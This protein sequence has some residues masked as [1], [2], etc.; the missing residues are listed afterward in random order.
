MKMCDEKNIRKMG[1]DPGEIISFGGGWVN[2]RAPEKLREVYMEICRDP[3][4]FHET[5]AYPPTPGLR[6]CREQLARMEE[7]LFGMEVNEDN[8]LISQSST[9]L[10]HDIFRIIAN[11]GDP[12]I[13]LDPTYANYYGQL[14]F[15]LTVRNG[16]Q[17]ARAEV[18]HIVTLDSERWEFIPDPDSTIANMEELFRRRHPKAILIPSPDNPTGQ[19]IPDK[20]M[21]A[22]LELC[23]EYDA[24]LII[25]Y[26][27]KTQCF[28]DTL[29]DYFRWSPG[30]IE[31]LILIY[32]NS[33]WARGL[34][35]RMGWIISSEKVVNGLTQMLNY[36]L[37][38]GDNMHQMAMARFLEESLSDGS[39]ERYLTDAN[40]LY[41]RAARVTVGSI[42][43]YCGLRRLVPQG[44][45]YTLMEIGDGSENL[46]LDIMKNTGVLLIPGTGFGDSSKNGVR[47]SYGPLVNDTGKIIEGMKRVGEYL[48]SRERR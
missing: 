21:E 1:L 24:Y 47:I 43:K 35:R 20:F 7:K 18:E 38:C 36:S 34:G 14:V 31:N 12:I 23:Q 29:P 13:L 2:H 15:S 17:N 48:K 32:S 22:A 39:L 44:G 30:E 37:L 46:I 45:L 19:V 27:Y 8:V 41:K 40:E 10:T 26:A 6:S 16:S 33:K 42:D 3:E 11:P 28:L 4:L 9:Q 5:G 25:D